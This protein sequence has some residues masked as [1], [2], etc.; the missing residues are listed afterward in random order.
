SSSTARPRSSSSARWPR[1]GTSAAGPRAT[2]GRQALPRTRRHA[3]EPDPR[4]DT[5]KACV[6]PRACG[7]RGLSALADYGRRRAVHAVE[8]TITV[9]GA[10]VEWIRRPSADV[11]DNFLVATLEEVTVRHARQRRVEG[12]VASARILDAVAVARVASGAGAAILHHVAGRNTGRQCGLRARPSIQT[13]RCARADCAGVAPP[14]A[15]ASA[16]GVRHVDGA[17]VVVV[18]AGYAHAA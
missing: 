9:V 14:G 12:T 15:G 6:P 5:P 13:V 11:F 16:G 1:R 17:T 4:G 18:V 2:C 7:R 3:R 8:P 10:V